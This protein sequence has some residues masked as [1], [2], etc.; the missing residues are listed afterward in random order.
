MN[1]ICIAGI[2]GQDAELTHMPDGTAIAKWSVADDQGQN[3]PTIW[4]RC[5]LFG[6][7]AESLVKWLTKGSRVT[8]TGNLTEREYTSRDGVVTKAQEVNVRDVALQGDRKQ[9]DEAPAPKAKSTRNAPPDADP[10][11]DSIPF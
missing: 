10:F 3:K 6:K 2:I 8:I 7:R 5:S 4:W 11:N 1:V 9:Q